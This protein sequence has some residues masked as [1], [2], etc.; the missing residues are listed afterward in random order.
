M[1][2]LEGEHRRPPRSSQR[3]KTK[4]KRRLHRPKRPMPALIN[5][6][7]VL[8]LGQWRELANISE[9]AERRMRAEGKGPTLTELTESRW[10]VTVAAHKAWLQA[11]TQKS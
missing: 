2:L 5:D 9:R 4:R 6:C 10:G 11:R 8:T 7:Q 1:S 3:T